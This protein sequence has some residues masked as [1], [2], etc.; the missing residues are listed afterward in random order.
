M[1]FQSITL[2]SLCSLF[3]SFRD[4]AASLLHPA[5]DLNNLYLGKTPYSRKLEYGISELK[6]T[7]VMMEVTAHL[8]YF[9][10]ALQLLSRSF[11]IQKNTPF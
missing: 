10:L 8:F 3:L 4:L 9:F 6:I 5:L 7:S 2:S 1:N 11:E